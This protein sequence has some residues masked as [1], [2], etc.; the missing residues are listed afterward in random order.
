MGTAVVGTIIVASSL[1][2]SHT[3]TRF[4]AIFNR[5]LQQD[6]LCFDRTE[7]KASLRHYLSFANPVGIIF[8]T[9]RLGAGKSTL[10]HSVLT[11]RVHVADINWRGKSIKTA[12]DL[13]ESLKDAFAIKTY[14]DQIKEMTGGIAIKR[15]LMLNLY[16]ILFPSLNFE[17]TDTCNLESTM[18]D[19]EKVLRFALTKGS[20]KLSRRPVIFIDEI[21]ALRGLANGSDED[22]EVAKSFVS[23]LIRIS[24]DWHLCDV[25]FASHDGFAMEILELA[26][27]AYCV[28]IVVPS[29]TQEDMKVV[30]K[31]FPHVT[32]S[33]SDSIYKY[34]AGHAEHVKKLI[35]VTSKSQMRG[36]LDK[37][38]T[39][40]RKA[41]AEVM[42]RAK[43]S[44]S[45]WYGKRDFSTDCYQKDD[46]IKV[47]NLLAESD[48]MDPE[49][50][51]D[52][53]IRQTAL[54]IQ[55]LQILTHHRLIFY[56]PGNETI[57]ARN[58]LFLTLYKEKYH[59]QAEIETLEANIAFDK[60]TRDDEEASSEH[61]ER[62][63]KSI[64]EAE[65]K[66]NQ[67]EKT[68]QTS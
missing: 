30:A 64:K 63:A 45:T 68:T 41:M 57:K 67:L 39:G 40:E 60:L 26:D 25:V 49:I 56:N 61:R 55:I 5:R 62:A 35:D 17:D 3:S 58:K 53:V 51:V 42:Q 7:F 59:Q 50:A 66:L 2:K 37:V 52:T 48:E 38:R 6:P 27:T 47:M 8:V 11:D 23:W 33:I 4:D 13:N 46:F 16:Q 54:N 28:P 12:E 32:Q 20:G 22:R 15:G 14:K 18:A 36:E 10:I 21:Q 24:R 34:V 29:F 44:C 19:I 31:H 9:G 43:T 65:L 1:M